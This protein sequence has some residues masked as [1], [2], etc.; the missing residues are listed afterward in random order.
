MLLDTL[1]LLPSPASV[2][3]LTLRIQRYRSAPCIT[4][5]RVFLMSV[6]VREALRTGSYVSLLKSIRAES[7]AQKGRPVWDGLL[8]CEF[9]TEHCQLTGPRRG[10][11]NGVCQ[12]IL[13]NYS[14]RGCAA[15]P[16]ASAPTPR[17]SHAHRPR[18]HYADKEGGRRVDVVPLTILVGQSRGHLDC[19]PP[20]PAAWGRGLSG[21]VD[22]PFSAAV[23]A[24]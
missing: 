22:S 23:Q 20:N 6:L 8:V 18:E 11:G 17:H 9:S 14:N 1:S 3:K 13:T 2:R 7:S 5:P 10:R 12:P 21:F 24:S 4:E 19:S 15:G 16:R